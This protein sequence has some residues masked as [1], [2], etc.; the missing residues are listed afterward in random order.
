MMEKIVNKLV[1]AGILFLIISTNIGA[2]VNRNELSNDEIKKI[3]ERLKLVADKVHTKTETQLMDSVLMA[4]DLNDEEDDD[5]PADELYEGEWNNEFVKAYSNADVPNTYQI[6][7]SSF[8]MPITGKVTS[9]YGPRSRRFHY[10]TDLKLQTGDTVYAAFDG[11]IRVCNYERRGY[12][13]Y[14][15]IRHPNGLE[16]VYG[17][18]SKNLV[19]IDDNV[20]AGQP[21]ALG[22]NTGRSTGSHL[23][24]E[25]RFLGQAIDPS[26]IIDFDHFCTYDDNYV[27]DKS[28]CGNSYFNIAF[29]TKYKP[30]KSKNAKYYAAKAMKSSKLKNSSA[31]SLANGNKATYHKVRTGDTLGAIAQ[32]YGVSVNQL[33]RLNRI[34]KTT[35]LKIGRS[36]RC[37]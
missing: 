3:G 33:C 4:L 31:A 17:H 25:F 16:T 10:G 1:A 34:G 14:V 18:L 28:R 24:F 9:P 20:L 19:N 37:S 32:R 2:Q 8:I 35:T 29:Y 12:G 23:H 36:L 6:D 7:V 27:F 5:L 30:L 11:K 13:N 26:E 22:G 21:I 15:V